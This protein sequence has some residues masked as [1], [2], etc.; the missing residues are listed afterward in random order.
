MEA[1]R[2]QFDFLGTK[3]EFATAVE[4]T[5]Y[6][7]DG[8]GIQRAGGEAPLVDLP[9]Y[10]Q[11]ID[12]AS[13]NL[14]VGLRAPEIMSNFSRSELESWNYV[15]RNQK[16]IDGVSV[17]VNFLYDYA[18]AVPNPPL[19]D[20][21][22]HGIG[23]GYC[24]RIPLETRILSLCLHATMVRRGPTQILHRVEF[25]A[26]SRHPDKYTEDTTKAYHPRQWKYQEIF[27]A[28]AFVVGATNGGKTA[29]SAEFHSPVE[30]FYR[31]ILAE[32][33]NQIIYVSDSVLRKTPD[34]KSIHYDGTDLKR[35]HSALINIFRESELKMLIRTELN[36][37]FEAIVGG[38]SFSDKVFE[39][40]TWAESRERLGELI[41][42]AHNERPKNQTLK[43]Y[44]ERAL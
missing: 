19:W 8:S 32:L 12:K 6:S 3:E 34:V 9:S 30:P 2:E 38:Q 29:I 16:N 31:F 23:E 24:I 15:S 17:S 42:A 26:M 7:A 20:L 18:L 1:N 44:A 33:G 22:R 37:R 35:L 14:F 4:Q 28:V 36:E 39:L 21:T 27:A 43:E 13:S 25:R 41:H 10:I 40:L 5:C 11:A